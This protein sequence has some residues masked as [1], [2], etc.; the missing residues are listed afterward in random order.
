MSDL[1]DDGIE[2]LDDVLTSDAIL[3]LVLTLD[4][5]GVVRIA[6][7]AAPECTDAV[8]D[9]LASAVEIVRAE[10]DASPQHQN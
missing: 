8:S 2:A 3:V 6:S 5:Q 1:Y 10:E 4:A 9:V 7:T